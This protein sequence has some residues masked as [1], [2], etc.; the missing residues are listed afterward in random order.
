MTEAK[1]GPC[2]FPISHP[3]S[4]VN[5]GGFPYFYKTNNGCLLLLLA[6]PASAQSTTILPICWLFCVLSSTNVKWWMPIRSHATLRYQPKAQSIQLY[7]HTHSSLPGGKTWKHYAW[8]N[9][10]RIG[11][12]RFSKQIRWEESLN[13]EPSKQYAWGKLPIANNVTAVRRMFQMKISQEASR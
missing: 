13:S 4:L 10:D 5:T 7:G 2:G 1:L 11:G 12:R 6:T 9:R 8:C 3:L